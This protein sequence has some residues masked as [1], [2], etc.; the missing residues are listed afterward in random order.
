MV[1]PESRRALGLRLTSEAQGPPC[2]CWSLSPLAAI[3]AQRPAVG[4]RPPPPRLGSGSFIDRS[5]ATVVLRGRGATAAASSPLCAASS[6]Q[7]TNSTLTSPR[8]IGW[9][10]G[11]VDLGRFLAEPDGS[12]APAGVL[13]SDG[14]LRRRIYI[15]ASGQ[16]IS[17]S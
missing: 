2:T 4:G 17:N 10:G 11:G 15:G 13:G 8:S 6:A 7:A 16:T 9:S 5:A 1:S 14:G 3:G 12:A